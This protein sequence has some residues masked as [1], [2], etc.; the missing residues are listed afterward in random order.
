MADHSGH[1]KRLRERFVNEGLANFPEHTALELLLT[2][3]IPRRDVNELAH[4]LIDRFGSISGVMDA[5]IDQLTKVPGI[6]HDT[7][8]L[9]NLIP[10]LGSRYMISRTNHSNIISSTDAAGKFLLPRFFGETEEVV[11]VVAMDGKGKVLDCRML[12]RG[13]VNS[14]AI[15]IRKVVE[16]AISTGCSSMILAHNHTSGVAVPSQEDRDTT[17]LVRTA[18]ATI[19]V[20]LADHI[21]VAD[22][23]YVSMAES[24]LLR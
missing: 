20:A 19:G 24:G 14:A 9:L 4:D 23:E 5:P 21:I 3:A 16:M 11:Y 12:F 10:Q 8:V 2:Y 1:R 18:L 17:N 13:S 15:S 22:G 6:G 7:A